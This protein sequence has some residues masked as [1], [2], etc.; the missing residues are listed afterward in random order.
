MATKRGKAKRS[1]GPRSIRPV[2]VQDCGSAE[3]HEGHR[4]RFSEKW[5]VGI[6]WWCRGRDEEEMR[7]GVIATQRAIRFSEKRDKPSRARARRVRKF[8]AERDSRS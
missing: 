1:R 6:Y 8:L 3:D 2:F 7:L 4:W 5:P